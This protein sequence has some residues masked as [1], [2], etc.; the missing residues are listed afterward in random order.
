MPHIPSESLDVKRVIEFIDDLLIATSEIIMPYFRAATPVVSKTA[1]G[2]DP[3]TQ[4]DREAEAFMRKRIAKTYP[5]HGVIGEELENRSRPCDW[6]WVLDPIDGTRSF[7][8]GTPVWGTLVGLKHA[9]QV[10][11]GGMGQPFTQERFLGSANGAFMRR[12]NART[13]LRSSATHTLA[14]AMMATTSPELFTP[15]TRARFTRLRQHVRQCSYGLDCYAFAM[16]AAGHMDI[17]I[18]AGLKA[19][20][21]CALIPIIEGAGGRVTNWQG[22][23]AQSGGNVIATANSALHE[24]ALRVLGDPR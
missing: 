5:E 11:A 4:A 15:Q 8:T 3:V 21:I 6:L 22:G 17:A 18:E 20:D 23:P 12:G 7:I 2:F 13:M 24:Q 14:D 19:Y 9:D 1:V 16:V 10:F